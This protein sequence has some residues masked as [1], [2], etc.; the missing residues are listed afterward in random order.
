MPSTT[1]W[2]VFLLFVFFAH[3]EMELPKKCVWFFVVFFWGGGGG[4][5][6][7]GKYNIPLEGDSSM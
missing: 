3:V 5:G 4:G 2:I 6:G 1:Y 7:G